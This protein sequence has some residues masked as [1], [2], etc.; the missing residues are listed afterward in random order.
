MFNFYG[1]RWSEFKHE[2]F[3]LL[4][5][6]IVQTWFNFK[7]PLFVRLGMPLSVIVCAIMSMS[8]IFCYCTI[9]LFPEIYAPHYNLEW[10]DDSPD[11]EFFK[12]IYTFCLRIIIWGGFFYFW[13]TD[14][15]GMSNVNYVF[16]FV[17]WFI[18]YMFMV[19]I[20]HRYNKWIEA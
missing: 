2:I 13:Y 12:E 6:A 19:R 9:F 14:Y 5:L 1:A 3:P 18:T 17:H 7:F 16:L 8:I 20:M 11:P 4:Y 15:Y 10:L